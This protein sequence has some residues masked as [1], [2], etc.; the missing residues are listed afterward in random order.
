[1]QEIIIHV[2]DV[3]WGGTNEFENKI[4]N[5]LGVTFLVGSE[6]ARSFTYTGIQIKQLKDHICFTQHDYVNDLK[7]LKLDYVSH[8]TTQLSSQTQSEYRRICCH[9]N[10][11]VSQSRS[12][13]SLDICQLSIKLGKANYYDA[14]RAN[15]VLKKLKLCTVTLYFWRLKSPF[16]LILHSDVSYANL[17]DG[18]S[19]SGMFIFLKKKQLTFLAIPKYPESS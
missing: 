6:V 17:E 13:I 16:E 3:L 14:Q 18:S 5:E 7:P 11:L 15:K 2:D 19:R 9:L 10:W 12:D 8:I 4:I 1:M